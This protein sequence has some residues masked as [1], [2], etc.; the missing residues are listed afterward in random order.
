MMILLW[1]KLS[2]SI[3]VHP[4]KP[5]VV[6][7]Y[8]LSTAHTAT[9]QRIFFLIPFFFLF[10]FW[11]VWHFCFI[12]GA[13]PFINTIIILIIIILIIARLFTLQLN[14]Q[15]SNNTVQCVCSW[16]KPLLNTVVSTCER[17]RNNRIFSLVSNPLETENIYFSFFFIFQ[18]NRWVTVIIVWTVSVNG[19][20]LTS[21]SISAVFFQFPDPLSFFFADI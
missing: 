18:F 11:P 2:L 3:V 7:L 8:K 13:K 10:L 9:E 14:T 1:S 12:I 6:L 4:V 15:Q 16:C 5:V 17:R 20:L 19:V 21:V